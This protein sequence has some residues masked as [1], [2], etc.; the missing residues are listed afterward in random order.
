MTVVDDGVL[1]VAAQEY[2]DAPGATATVPAW[3]TAAFSRSGWVRTSASTAEIAVE[4]V[5]GRGRA[6]NGG[7]LPQIEGLP[8]AGDFPVAATVSIPVTVLRFSRGRATGTVE[9]ADISAPLA[10]TWSSHVTQPAAMRRLGA[11]GL[12][13]ADDKGAVLLLGDLLIRADMWE[14]GVVGRPARVRT[15]AMT[16][17]IVDALGPAQSA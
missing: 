8:M 10:R 17:E 4:F 1:V 12:V 16:R 2:L 14:E 3:I 5:D 15:G 6:A 11:G 9:I 7:D 13:H